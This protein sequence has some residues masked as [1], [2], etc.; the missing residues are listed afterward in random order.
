MDVLFSDPDR[1]DCVIV[2]RSG[3]YRVPV[4][5]RCPYAWQTLFVA[6]MEAS[7]SQWTIIWEFSC[8]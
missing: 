1:I 7:T 6:W 2:K 4:T 8:P 5:G 3:R